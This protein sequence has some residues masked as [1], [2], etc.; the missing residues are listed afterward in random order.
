MWPS[1]YARFKEDFVDD[2]IYLFEAGVEWGD[3]EDPVVVLRRLL[4]ID[5]ARKELTRGLILKMS[6]GQ[7]GPEAIDGV[8]RVLKRS[9][10]PCTVYLMVRDGSGRTAQLRLGDEWRVHPAQ[11]KVDE[12]EMMLGEGAVLFTGK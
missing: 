4:T 7:H 9:P 2:R 12:L 8:E 1:D 3:R 5:Q 11:I 6:L 10:G